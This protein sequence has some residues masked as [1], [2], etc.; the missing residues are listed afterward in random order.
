MAILRSAVAAARRQL[1]AARRQL[2]A[3][4]HTARHHPLA[5]AMAVC[6]PV[7]LLFLLTADTNLFPSLIH[8]PRTVPATGPSLGGPSTAEAVSTPTFTAYRNRL[9]SQSRASANSSNAFHLDPAMSMEQMMSL[10]HLGGGSPPNFDFP[11]MLTRS[12]V[13]WGPDI[14]Q[15]YLDSCFPIEISTSQGGRSIGHCSDFVQYIYHAG[16]R[17][18]PQF[19]GSE[20]YEEKLRRCPDS[21]YLHG[22][23]PIN[24]LFE[25]TKETKPAAR[26]FWMPN[27]EQIKI[28][29]A[30]LVNLTHT[31][32]AKTRVTAKALTDYMR[33]NEIYGPAVRFM[34]HSTPDPM[35]QL[36]GKSV[37]MDYTKFFHGY[38]HSGRKQTRQLIECWLEHPEF[39]TLT[40]VGNTP[41]EDLIREHSDA[42]R[43]LAS[44]H[45][46]QNYTDDRFPPNLV[47]SSSLDPDTFLATA[48]SSGVHLCPSLMEG[49][50]HYINVA[51]A[52]GALPITSAH[53]PMSEFVTDATDGVLIHSKAGAGSNSAEYYQLIREPVFVMPYGLSPDDICA[54]VQRVVDMPVASRAKL[55]RA[56]RA[57]YDADTTE[58][59]AR[60]GALLVDAFDGFSSAPRPARAVRRGGSEESPARGTVGLQGANYYARRVAP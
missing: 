37:Q 14:E 45:P 35:T 49:Y 2:A 9:L 6:A 46:N 54:A 29:Q 59:A 12:F 51:R 53:P 33:L 27:L 58:M 50:G 21:I 48:A 28:E 7:L 34:Y 47:V 60:L 39:P 31:F 36:V 4:A 17:L 22:E 1:A 43:R 32:L 41:P 8:R 42:L 56:A 13:A 30:P 5:C 44:A 52:L 55:G 10:C 19:M 15:I 3:P 11:V 24:L 38:G 20:V 57:H 40:V 25:G 23:Y 26:N 16:A 18:S